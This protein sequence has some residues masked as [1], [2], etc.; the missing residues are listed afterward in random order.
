MATY[1]RENLVRLV[2]RLGRLEQ[3]PMEVVAGRRHVASTIL[4]AALG[5]GQ[6]GN[7]RQASPVAP[8]PR[9]AL[10]AE[11]GL[12]AE[13][14]GTAGASVRVAPVEPLLAHAGRLDCGRVRYAALKQPDDEV[15]G[16]VR[17]LHG[18]N[19]GGGVSATSEHVR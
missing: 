15:G 19:R 13:E 3:L 5:E 10:A 4:D 18:L 1:P 11:H 8:A 14:V 12:L 17:A 6:L 9:K 7:Q 2:L 16:R